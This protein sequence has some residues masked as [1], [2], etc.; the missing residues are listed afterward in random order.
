VKT[1]ENTAVSLPAAPSDGGGSALNSEVKKLAVKIISS[2]KLVKFQCPFIVSFFG[3]D[4]SCHSPQEAEIDGRQ[5][6]KPASTQI[7]CCFAGKPALSSHQSGLISAPN[8]QRKTG[9]NI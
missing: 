8:N 9:A 5:T 3:R 2:R 1:P 4:F 6:R 7:T